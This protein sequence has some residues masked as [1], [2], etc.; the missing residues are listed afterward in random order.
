[1]SD[2]L[3]QLAVRVIPLGF[4]AHRNFTGARPSMGIKGATI[5]APQQPKFTLGADGVI[6]P[7]A[8][9]DQPFEYEES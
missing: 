3:Y 8:V 7:E 4:T 2:D 1:M 5:E 6:Q 9:A